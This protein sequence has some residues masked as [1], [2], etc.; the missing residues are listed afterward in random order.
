MARFSGSLEVDNLVMLMSALL[1]KEAVFVPGDTVIVLD[2]I[3]ACP[4]ARTALKFLS[5]TVGL[6]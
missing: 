2:E 1:G 3:Q 5:S 6:T 4:D